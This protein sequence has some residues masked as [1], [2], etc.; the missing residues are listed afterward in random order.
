MWQESITA[1]DKVVN[2]S[3]MTDAA[4]EAWKVE[5]EQDNMQFNEGETQGSCAVEIVKGTEAF[6]EDI[7]P[8]TSIPTGVEEF[9][10]VDINHALVSELGGT[11]DYINN[12][13]IADIKTGKRKPS[14]ANYSTQ[15]S[16]Y[17]YLAQENGI[18][19]QHNL[20]QSVI[21]KKVPEG[22]IIPMEANVPQAKALVNIML[23]TLDLVMKDVAPIE[24]ILRPNP[25]YMFCS[26]RFCAFYGKCPG[27][28]D[29]I[30]QPKTIAATKL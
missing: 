11:I 27:T 30:R 24:T 29:S 25:K 18:D 16:I 12:N 14:V 6:I 15:Q 5:N 20:I 23:D 9:F 26:Q 19:V 28:M 7:V 10:K 8:F 13:T 21:L 4:M 17:K 2:L 3:M 1:G 22:A